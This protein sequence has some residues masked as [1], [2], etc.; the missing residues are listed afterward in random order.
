[1]FAFMVVVP[2]FSSPLWPVSLGSVLKRLKIA[3]DRR[4][5]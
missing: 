4:N 5:D 1:V 2:L 3:S